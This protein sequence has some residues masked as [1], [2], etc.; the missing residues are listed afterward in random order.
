MTVCDFDQNTMSLDEDPH[1]SD[2]LDVITHDTNNI[3]QAIRGYALLLRIKL[4]KGELSQETLEEAIDVFLSQT[5]E[6]K[7][8]MRD[9]AAHSQD[10]RSGA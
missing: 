6:L 9:V 10:L 5:D 4:E 8:L 1:I 7:G 2:L 3:A